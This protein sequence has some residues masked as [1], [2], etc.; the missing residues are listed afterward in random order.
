M[1]PKEFTSRCSTIIL[2]T[3]SSYGIALAAEQV[4]PRAA[5]QNGNGMSIQTP[6]VDNAINTRVK[7]ALTANQING[8]AVQTELG[9]VTL[10]GTVATEEQ[11]QKAANI[12]ASV[13]GVRNV[14][15]ASLSVKRGA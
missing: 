13:E 10:A 3:A 11:R 4:T 14:D 8:L 12:A 5:T 6:A 15:I 9:V 7:S 1:S 2:I